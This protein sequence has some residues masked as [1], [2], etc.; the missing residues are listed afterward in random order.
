[1]AGTHLPEQRQK[2][3]QGPGRP[4]QAA[5]RVRSPSFMV[6]LRHRPAA[7]LNQVG[8]SRL[9]T[10]S[11]GTELLPTAQVQATLESS[12]GHTG[13]R[14]QAAGSAPKWKASW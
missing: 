13:G 1:M 2:L 4:Q 11:V 6:G 10:G 14:M 12:P 9:T 5:G 3:P 7:Q 8:A